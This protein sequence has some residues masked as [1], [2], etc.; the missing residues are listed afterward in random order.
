MPADETLIG[1][2]LRRARQRRGMTLRA[3]ADRAGVTESF[4]SQVERDIASPS[5]AT[6]RRIAM[7]L[8]TSIGALLEGAGPQAHLVRRADRRS[9]GYPGL[10]AR[11]EF[12]T[13]GPNARLQVIESVIEPGGGTGPEAYAHESDE[14]CLVILEGCLDLWVGDEHYRLEEGDAIR[15]SSRIAHRNENPGPSRARVLFVLTPPSF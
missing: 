10:D 7:A 2:S 8:G 13:D 11:D 5:I 3:V 12:L 6:L 4:L 14:E 9:V 15:Y 1:H